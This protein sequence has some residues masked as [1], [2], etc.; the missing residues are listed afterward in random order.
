MF[1]KIV[2]LEPILMTDEG[3]EELKSYA[4]DIIYYDTKPTTEEEV[5]D[6]INNADCV[7][8]S[9]TT[10]IT[11]NVLDRCNNIKYIGMSC[12]FY[13]DE[14]SNLDMITAREKNITVKYLKDYGDEGVVEYIVSDKNVTISADKNMKG[15]DSYPVYIVKGCTI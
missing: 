10:K 5:I 12:S 13:G 9:F 4:K 15:T 8:L 2:V 7:L 3:K 11:K 14:Y 6:R 1:E